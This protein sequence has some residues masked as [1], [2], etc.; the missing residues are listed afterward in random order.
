M[1]SR[2]FSVFSLIIYFML[3]SVFDYDSFF[4]FLDGYDFLPPHFDYDSFLIFWIDYDFFPGNFLYNSSNTSSCENE[5]SGWDY[6]NNDYDP[7]DDHGHGTTVAKIITKQL[8]THNI[9]YS[10]LAVKTFD[11][12]GIGSYWANVCGINYL[13]KKQDN[14][15]VNTSFGF[16]GITDQD[17]FKNTFIC[18]I[19]RSTSSS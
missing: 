5:V 11:Q 19:K 12:N 8:D 14:F 4:D 7:R 10:I 1:L 15:I 6:V 9:P 16:Y 13:A 17:I 18:N 2:F 3:S